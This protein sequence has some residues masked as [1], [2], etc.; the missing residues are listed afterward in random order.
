MAI[1]TL[2][3]TS[4]YHDLRAAYFAHD[5]PGARA[6]AAA[7]EHDGHAADDDVLNADGQLHGLGE[8]GAVGDGGGVKDDH[9]RHLPALEAPAIGEVHRVRRLRR[10]LANGLFE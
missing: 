4:G 8:G 5:A 7:A 3:M 9:V 2:T 1:P 10:H 6:G